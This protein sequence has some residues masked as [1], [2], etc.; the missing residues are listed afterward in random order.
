MF[1]MGK[2]VVVW[3]RAIALP[4]YKGK[5]DRNECKNYKEISLLSIP[6]KVYGM[7]LIE[8]LKC[9]TEGLKGEEQ[10]MFRRGKGCL[11]QIFMMRQAI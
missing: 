10:C 4:I 6:G 5:G 8:K 9:I 3:K 7:V 2:V 1:L 11:D